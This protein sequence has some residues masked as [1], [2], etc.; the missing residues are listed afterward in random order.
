MKTKFTIF[1]LLIS[2]FAFSQSFEFG[3]GLAT[4]STY[5]IENSDSSVN[6]NYKTPSSIYTDLK[7]IPNNSNVGILLRYQYTNTSVNGQKWFETNQNF[8]AI[9]AD[10]SLILLLEYLKTNE[11]RLSFGGNA[12]LG[13]TKQT[14]NFTDENYSTE[15]SF[16]SINISGIANYKFNNKFSI[17]LQPTFQFFDPISGMKIK[18]YNFVKEDIHFLALLGVSYKL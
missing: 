11:Q 12:G 7:Y 13:F 15:N 2:T 14:I 4:G 5:L 1:S 10:N 17:K 18:Q 16:P 9:V 8:N 3:V 6:I